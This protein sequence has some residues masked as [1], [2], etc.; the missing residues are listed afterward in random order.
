M[1]EEGRSVALRVV[2]VPW[3]RHSRGAMI[4]VQVCAHTCTLCGSLELRV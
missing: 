2:A 3:Q 1:C 4:R